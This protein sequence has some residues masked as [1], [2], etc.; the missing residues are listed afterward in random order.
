MA[1]ERN[2]GLHGGCDYRSRPTIYFGSM[3]SESESRL[4]VSSQKTY[5]PTPLHGTLLLGE[6]SI[7]MSCL[8]HAWATDYWGI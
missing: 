8:D 4:H 6:E 1:E 5:V 7:Y 2:D 3:L